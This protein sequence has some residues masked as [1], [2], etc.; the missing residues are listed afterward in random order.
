M[1]LS[2]EYT[3]ENDVIQTE[4]I[5]CGHLHTVVW[6]TGG[7]FQ[8]DRTHF[9]YQNG[10]AEICAGFGP[11]RLEALAVLNDV[12]FTTPKLVYDY[13]RDLRQIIDLC[14]HGTLT[15]KDA[16]NADLNIWRNCSWDLAEAMSLNGQERPFPVKDECAIPT[17]YAMRVTLVW[18]QLLDDD[19]P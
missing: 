8:G 15:E 10:N 11:R 7:E 12:S 5:K 6:S 19:P 18:T 4:L 3:D 9:P 1:S 13:L 17:T 14:A 2:F 16:A